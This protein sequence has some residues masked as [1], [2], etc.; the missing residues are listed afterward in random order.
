VA[1]E[2]HVR[3][4]PA[5]L[6]VRSGGNG[7][8][9]YGIAVPYGVE[10][11]IPH[12]GITES[13]TRGAFNHQIPAI[14]RVTYARGHQSMGGQITGHLT[15][16]RDDTAGL[17]VEMQVSKTPLGDETLELVRDGSLPDLSVGFN[18]G[19][20]RIS[21]QRVERTRADLTEVASVP[22]GAYGEMAQAAGVRS[23]N[24]PC[25]TCG[26]VGARAQTRSNLDIANQLIAGLPVLTI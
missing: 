13:F 19:T 12:E 4:F 20:N 10:Q 5:T 9:V 16:A 6:E 17:Y 24:V 15:H 2:Q 23:A 22:L 25:P 26:H 18:E 11:Y 21:G 8:T 1:N 14:H 7:R 3:A